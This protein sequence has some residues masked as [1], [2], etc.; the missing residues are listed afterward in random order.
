MMGP[1]II[2]TRA[3]TFLQKPGVFSPRL[4]FVSNQSPSVRHA[5]IFQ[6]LGLSAV[7]IFLGAGAGGILE[8]P[9]SPSTVL[10]GG[11]VL[12]SLP[13]ARTPARGMG[14]YVYKPFF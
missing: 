3:G 13:V 4:C 11:Q 6:T 1:M 10:D 9:A 2:V 7:V 5:R 12:G 8:T 14:A